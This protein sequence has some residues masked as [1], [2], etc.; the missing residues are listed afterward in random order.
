M[1][2][3]EENLQIVIES[4]K[5]EP[6]CPIKWRPLKV[7]AKSHESSLLISNIVKGPV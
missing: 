2:P 4:F 7:C 6:L 3:C 1:I 5:P